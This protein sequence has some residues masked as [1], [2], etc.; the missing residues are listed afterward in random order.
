MKQIPLKLSL[1]TRFTN[2]LDGLEISRR[3]FITI[4]AT[5]IRLKFPQTFWL[6]ML[7]T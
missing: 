7:L 2:D 3:E 1:I 5:I 6:G 4:V